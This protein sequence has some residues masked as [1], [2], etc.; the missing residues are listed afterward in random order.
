MRPLQRRWW[1]RCSL[2]HVRPKSSLRCVSARCGVPPNSRGKTLRNAPGRSMAPPAPSE[3]SALL[4]APEKPG[5]NFGGGPLRSAAM[6][7]YLERRYDVHVVTPLL[8][9]H[10]K[11]M[12]ARMWRNASRL[13][14][15]VP[16]LFDRYS[17]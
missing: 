16:P 13:V 7:T 6:Q 9:A 12:A 8:R 3:N 10:S 11:A 15:D 4:L 17:G 2:L 5:L 1:K 14:R